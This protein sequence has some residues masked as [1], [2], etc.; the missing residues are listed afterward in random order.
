MDTKPFNS[1]VCDV[2]IGALDDETDNDN[3]ER[4][5]SRPHSTEFEV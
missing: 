4:G 5:G 3:D 1:D 2:I